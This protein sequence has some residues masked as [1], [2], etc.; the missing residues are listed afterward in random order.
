MN[1]IDYKIRTCSNKK[2]HSDSLQQNKTIQRI[3]FRFRWFI[4]KRWNQSALNSNQVLIQNNTDNIIKT[5]PLTPNET[6][7]KTHIVN[8]SIQINIDNTNDLHDIINNETS[9]DF[10]WNK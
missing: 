10:K 8:E 5:H 4:D 7:Q 2:T 1:N 9:E 6:V 3:R